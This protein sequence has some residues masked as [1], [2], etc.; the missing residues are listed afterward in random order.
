[1]VIDQLG[2]HTKR[3]VPPGGGLLTSASKTLNPYLPKPCIAHRYITIPTG[4][5]TLTTL[6]L[7]KR[8]IACDMSESGWST[9]SSVGLVRFELQNCVKSATLTKNLNAKGVSRIVC[10]HR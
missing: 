1:M 2:A 9:R 10:V 4:Y 7:G 3:R 8:K 6:P 5:T